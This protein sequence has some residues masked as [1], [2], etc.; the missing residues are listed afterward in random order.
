MSHLI[1]YKIVAD[2]DHIL[3]KAARTA[4]NFWNHYVSSDGNIVIRLGLF[5]EESQTIACSY[6]PY[7]SKGVTYGQVDF[8][9]KYLG[10]YT[11][12]ELAGT[13]THEIGHTLGF[14]WRQW[15]K[16]FHHSTG[17]FRPEFTAKLPELEHMSVETNYGDGTKL[18]HWDEARFGREIMTGFKD[19]AE[20]VLPVTIDVLALLGHEVLVKLEKK[21]RADVLMGEAAIRTFT[22][23]ALAK[24]IDR[25]HFQKTDIWEKIPRA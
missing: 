18:A 17:K 9:T 21:T 12:L 5:T 1:T 16:L 2:Q 7:S 23:H 11:D 24:Q 14:G 22:R 3:K 6:E 8:N 15:M 20:F 19:K 13:V 10:E 25:D 4:C